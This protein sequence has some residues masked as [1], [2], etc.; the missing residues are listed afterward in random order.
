MYIYI[1]VC[2]FFFLN[3]QILL[4]LFLF[5]FAFF[6]SFFFFLFSIFNN[7]HVARL[8]LSSCLQK[9]KI[10]FFQ[11]CFKSSVYKILI[12]NTLNHIHFVP[13]LIFHISHPYSYSYSFLHLFICSFVHLMS[14][15]HMCLY[16]SQS[17]S[18]LVS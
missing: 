9:H 10:A 17:V 4:L 12:Y 2:V 3:S 15:Y 7:L 18:K 6:F 13:H 8:K 5:L 1:Y 16:I 14:S 11:S